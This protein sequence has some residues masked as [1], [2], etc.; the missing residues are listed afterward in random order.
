MGMEHSVQAKS[1]EWFRGNIVQSHGQPGR[2][3]SNSTD[4]ASVYTV[5]LETQSPVAHSAN[6]S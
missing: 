3:L 6:I 5:P 2:I 4:R 1:I